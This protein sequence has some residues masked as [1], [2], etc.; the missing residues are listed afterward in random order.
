MSKLRVIAP[1]QIRRPL[2]KEL[3]GLGCVELGA[4]AQRLADPEW[5]GSL[6]KFSEAGDADRQLG[7]LA[8]ARDLLDKHAPTKSGF[9][10]PRRPVTEAV[11]SDDALWAQA[12]AGAGQINDL[13]RQITLCYGEEGRLSVK[14][15]A[16]LPWRSLEVPLDI[17]AG[18]AYRALFGV[19]PATGPPAQELIDAAE[20]KAFAVMTLLHSDREQNYYFLILHNDVYDE[21]MDELKAKG[22]TLSVFKDT[23]G[24]ADSNILQLEHRLK[25]LEDQRQSLLEGIKALAGQKPLIEQAMDAL[26]IESQ[27]DQVLNNLAATRQTLFLEGWTPAQSEGAVSQVL[28]RYGCAY[29]F[30]PPEEGDDPPVLLANS[31]LVRPFGM[32]TELYALPT[33]ESKLDPNP[34]MAP[35]FFIFFGLMMGDIAY[36]AIITL[37]CW[38]ILKKAKPPEDGMMGRLMK[39]GF[40]CGISTIIWGAFFGGF[41]GNLIPSVSGAMLGHEVS[42]RPIL[43]DPMVDPMK[44]FILALV[45]GFIQVILG[46]CLNAYKMILQGD[47]LGAVFDVGFWLLILIGVPLCLV[48]VPVGLGF[49]AAGALGVLCTAGRAKP[50]LFGKITEGLGALYGITGYLSDILSYSR[51]LALSLGTAVIAQVMNTM[52]TL[53][54]GTLVGWLLFIIVFIVGHVFNVAINLIGTYVHTSRLQYIEFFGKFFDSGGRPFSPLFNK[55][56][57]VE[58]IKEGK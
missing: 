28:E 14:R 16:L 39:V 52:G 46:L 56:K 51:L 18:K 19:S 27:R 25:E 15:A 31:K 35:F 11:F 53:A 17:K 50:G 1:L 9:L 23:E 41:F 30:S 8:A 48:A 33:Y 55:T 36:G 43:F 2:L 32:V 12:L 24:T 34:F 29:G 10:S 57:Y 40:Y 13:G 7:I 6:E 22:F 21:V 5:A 47:P 37:V 42:I 3:T 45:F 49:M 38:Y 20:Q 44:L 26:T 54:G 58:I 4:S